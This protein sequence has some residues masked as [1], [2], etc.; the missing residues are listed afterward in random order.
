MA[1]STDFQP[2]EKLPTLGVSDKAPNPWIR[3]G[4]PILTGLI[5]AIIALAII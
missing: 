3:W 5:V 2:G 4:L 1:D